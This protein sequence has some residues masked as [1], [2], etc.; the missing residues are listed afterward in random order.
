[1]SRELF[2]W[3]FAVFWGEEHVERHGLG[4]I[5]RAELQQLLC[6]AKERGA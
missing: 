5:I 1:M 6:E 2:Y 3:L 4:S